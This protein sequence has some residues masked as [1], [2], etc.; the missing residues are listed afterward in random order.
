M[1]RAAS[2]VAGIHRRPSLSL[3]PVAARHRPPR[4]P[5]P[6]AVASWGRQ[7][8]RRSGRIWAPRGQIWEAPAVAG[9]APVVASGAWIPRRRR[10]SRAASSDPSLS[11]SRV[12]GLTGGR[13][14]R[15]HPSSSA[16]RLRGVV[17]G[18]HLLPTTRARGGTVKCGVVA[19]SMGHSPSH[20]LCNASPGS[21]S[22]L[23]VAEECD[24]QRGAA[25]LAEETGL[26]EKLTEGRRPFLGR[27]PK[28]THCGWPGI[29]IS[30]FYRSTCQ[31][32]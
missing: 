9:T 21:V 8:R 27:R 28:D 11:L 1:R 5:P 32:L 14:P 16:R 13:V 25:R 30:P 2:P 3:S 17:A 6:R 24:L 23:K 7:I 10:R 31:C 12:T 29:W 18:R 15:R 22:Q 20:A 26:T 19:V 4:H